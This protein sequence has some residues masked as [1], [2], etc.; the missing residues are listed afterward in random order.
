M[1]V[2]HNIRSLDHFWPPVVQCY[3]LKTPFGLLIP[4]ITIPITRNYIHSQLFSYAVP[5]LHSLQSYTFVTTITYYT[6]TLA[7]FSAISSFFLSLVLQPSF[8][9]WPTSMKLSV[10][11]RQL[12]ITVSNYHTLYIFTLW[13][14]RR[15]LTP[16]IH[17]LRLLL[18]NCLLNSHSGNWSKP[19]N[20]FAYTAELC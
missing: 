9:P 2:L 20:S 14:S 12:S 13:N 8:G 4:F 15:D 6:L 16:R 5:H 11:P 3:A 19:A 1:N 7:D 18:N 10:P 17:F